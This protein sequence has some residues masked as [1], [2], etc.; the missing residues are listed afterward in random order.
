MTKKNYEAIAS[1]IHRHRSEDTSGTGSGTLSMVADS[2]ANIFQADNPRFN[3]AQFFAACGMDE[4][5]I[6]VI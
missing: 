6:W 4:D 1:M 2:L 3:R 5:G